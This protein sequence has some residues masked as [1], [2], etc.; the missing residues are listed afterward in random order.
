M[1]ILHSKIEK[2]ENKK[3]WHWEVLVQVDANIKAK[4]SGNTP[5]RA[6]AREAIRACK[7]AT[8]K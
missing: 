5:T 3:C 6:S 8:A 4:L 2:L 1:S 7:Q